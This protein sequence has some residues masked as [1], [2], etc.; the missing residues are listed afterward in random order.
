MELPGSEVVRGG[1]VHRVVRG[2]TLWSIA[3]AYGVGVRDLIRANR[4]SDA[5]KIEVGQAIRIPGP[6]VQM[7]PDPSVA[8]DATEFI[9]P[10]EGKVISI[11]GMRQG[12]L[13]NKGIDI[14]APLGREV[15]A[16]RGGLVSFIHEGLPGFGK[17][18]IIDHRDGFATVYAYVGQI[19]VEKGERVAQ[20][21]IIA[22]VGRT[23]RT[24]VS[25]LHF[26]VRRNQRPENPFHYL[27]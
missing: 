2:E 13:L 19:L 17:T 23:G 14:Q 7:R 15:L 5:T 18:I 22:R 24:D 25:A 1:V 21:Q 12:T 4:I 11:F 27:P 6:K 26:E 16:A 9:W 8:S 10:V 3:K 20:R